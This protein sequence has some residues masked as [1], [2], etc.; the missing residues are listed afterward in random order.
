MGQEAIKRENDF[1]EI[2]IDDIKK[3]INNLGLDNNLYTLLP[4]MQPDICIKC[5]DKTSLSRLLENIEEIKD[6]KGKKIFLPRYKNEGNAVNISIKH[7]IDAY[8]TKSFLV[9]G[10]LFKAKD[11]NIQFIRRDIGTGYHTKEGIY[12]GY[13]KKSFDLFKSYGSNDIDTRDFFNKIKEYFS[14]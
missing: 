14:V 6:I 12:I 5:K 8:Q 9:K 4:A 7:S 2:Y 10:K 13:G 3:L 11:L 1:P